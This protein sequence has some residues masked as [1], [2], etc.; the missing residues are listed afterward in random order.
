M[1][2]LSSSKRRV[3]PFRLSGGECLSSPIFATSPLRLG[4][5][6]SEFDARLRQV[7][8]WTGLLKTMVVAM[9]SDGAQWIRIS[10]EEIL[11]GR[12][13]IFILDVF[14]ALICVAAAQTLTPDKS[15]RKLRMDWIKEQLNA[16]QVAQVI[17]TL[18]PHGDRSEAVAACIR[19][20]ETN[21]DRMRN[22][23]CRKLGLPVGSS[24][25]ESAC[26]QDRQQP[27]QAGCMPLVEGRSQR[28]ARRQMLLEEQPLDRRPRVEGL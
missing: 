5:G 7:A 1:F 3:K 4:G 28:L 21:A 23:L 10:C 18:K 12:K 8:R 26:K 22:D 19:T 14:H 17:V 11:A 25:V 9:L 13:V 16:G 27:T 15:E 20:Y 2:S 6:T 24:V